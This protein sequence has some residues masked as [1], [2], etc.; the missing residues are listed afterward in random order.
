MSTTRSPLAAAIRWCAVSTAGIEAAP[1]SVMPSTSAALVMVEAVPM[2]MQVPG[3]RASPRS[4][5]D[6]FSSPMRPARLSSQ[7]FHMS[8][9]LPRISL[10]QWPLIIGPAGTKI[11]GSLAL[12]APMSSAGVLLSQPPMST[13]P[14]IG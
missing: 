9:P 8:V 11:A 5:S 10:R 13:A 14:S 1:G 6:I 2:V 4:S 7:Y 12:A 3:E